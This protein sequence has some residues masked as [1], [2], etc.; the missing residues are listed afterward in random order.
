MKDALEHTEY[1]ENEKAKLKMESSINM[2]NLRHEIQGEIIM[3]KFSRQW[4]K[5]QAQSNAEND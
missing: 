1:N 2:K 5:V 4:G 3:V